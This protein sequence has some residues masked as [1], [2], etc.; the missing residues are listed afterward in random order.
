MLRLT[1]NRGLRGAAR[2]AARDQRG[3]AAVEFALIAPLMILL[4]FGLSQLSELVIAN[5]H[6]NHATSTLG[7]LVSQCSSINDTDTSNIWAATPDIMSPLSVSASNLTQRVTSV[8]VNTGGVPQVAWSKVPSGQTSPAAYAL[9]TNITLPANL[10][11]GSGDS[12]V[13]AETT[14][15]FSFPVNILSNAVKFS[16][17]T[18]F[19]PR[20]S[21]VVTYTGSGPGGTGSATSCYGS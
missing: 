2:Q 11:N 12:V 14:Y 6:T 19:K 1:F 16:D 5:R 13:M 20:K 10:V 8:V 18:Y 15:S 9:G 21:T 7:D 17:V 4:Y 3:V